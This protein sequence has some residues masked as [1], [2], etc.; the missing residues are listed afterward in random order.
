MAEE[1]RLKFVEERDGVDGA[2]DFAKQ[3]LKVYRMALRRSRKRG[4]NPPHHATLPEY[5]LGFIESC[6][7]FRAYL[8]KEEVS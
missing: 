4:F 3:T 6:L 5:R 1:Q 7:D 8:R 2:I